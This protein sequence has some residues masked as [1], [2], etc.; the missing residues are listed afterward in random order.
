MIVSLR[1]SLLASDAT[2][3]YLRAR[4]IIEPHAAQPSTAAPRLPTGASES[5]SRVKKEEDSS[6]NDASTSG[7]SNKRTSSSLGLNDLSADSEDIDDLDP[8]DIAA[9]AR[10]KVCCT[11]FS[12]VGCDYD[13]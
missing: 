11:R 6:K 10:L 2:E 7:S 3:D 5:D 9:I 8:E 12:L 4:E 1:T 13:I